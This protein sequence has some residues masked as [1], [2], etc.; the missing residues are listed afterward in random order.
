[1]TIVWAGDIA[2]CRY[3]L[4]YSCNE[5]TVIHTSGSDDDGTHKVL[6]QLASQTNTTY[7][8]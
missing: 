3:I 4:Q 2:D 1:M 8:T 5:I 7:K 6:R